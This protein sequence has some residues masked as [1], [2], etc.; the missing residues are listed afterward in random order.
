MQR[1]S[2]AQILGAL[3]VKQQENSLYQ[4]SHVTLKYV[5]FSFK[6][7][8]QLFAAIIVIVKKRLR[9]FVVIFDIIIGIQ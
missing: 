3:R 7:T 2:L 4:L 5:D 9:I 6:D 1:V 8:V